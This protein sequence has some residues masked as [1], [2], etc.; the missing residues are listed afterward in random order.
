MTDDGLPDLFWAVAR[1]LRGRTRVA[2]EPLGITPSLSRA[3]GV[4][5]GDAP[6]R[7]TALAE[8]LRV[9]PRTATELVDDLAARGL[10]AREPDPGDRRAVLV[11]PTPAGAEAAARIRTAREAE[12]TRFFAALGDADQGELARL[13][14]A[15][16]E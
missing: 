13:L 7:V 11:R 3:L 15:L 16:Q 10:A 6:M 4:L 2:L 5:A 9:A 1:S 14:R 8:R 12:A